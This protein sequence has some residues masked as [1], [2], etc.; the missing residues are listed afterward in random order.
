MLATNSP[1][2]GVYTIENDLS[3]RIAAAST[4]IGAIVG[5]SHRGPVGVP[6]LVVDQAD[7]RAQFGLKDA[8]LSYMHYCAE[9]FLEEASRMYVVRVALEAKH[10]GIF[11]EKDN[12][13][14]PRALAAGFED[15]AEVTFAA[16]DVLFFY[17]ANPGEWNNKLR[18]TIYPKVSDPDGQ[19]FILQIFEGDS[20]IPVEQFECTTHDNVDGSGTQTF[21]EDVINENSKVVRV[22]L[23]K[24]HPEFAQ[25][26]KPNLMNA[27]CQGPLV[28]GDN[29]VDV[30]M[31]NNESL[32]AL[33]DAWDL[34]EDWE[35]IDVN[36]LINA[37]YTHVAFQ[38]KMDEI[39]RIRQDCIAV[40]DVPKNDQEASEAVA[41][42]RNNFL[43]STSSS[44]L[45]SPNLL[46]RDE[47][48]GRDVWVPPSGHIAAVYARTD[49]DAATWFAPAGLIRGQ[50]K[51]VKALAEDY[52]LGHRD[53]LVENQINSIRNMSGNG[54]VVWGAD[55]AYST[56]S[57]LTDVGVRRMLA[58]L[59]ASVRLNNLS[60]VFEPNDDFLRSQQ[61]QAGEALL[62]P[63]KRGRGLYW[64]EV[65]C[66]K[67]NNTDNLIGNGDLIVDYYLDP[68]RFVKRI[69]LNAIIPRTG[70]IQFAE[71]LI[72]STN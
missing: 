4:S 39:A 65:I 41:W 69:H 14:V 56:P 59:H 61:R 25:N 23:N 24:A 47:I 21:I 16:N 70:G 38:H 68:T 43:L 58:F 10:G 32:S 37:G 9:A 35:L 11:F 53:I 22:V 28:G 12:F 34:F 31:S 72:D 33:I 7:F 19:L 71:S 40:L 18:I 66:D 48:N 55:T 44:A 36:I 63:I 1:S 26:P 67:R 15:L 13:S 3:Q 62:E 8:R 17:G 2:A 57:A 5:A 27:I 42:R 30:Q 60:P 45:Y 51:G 54:I 50:L 6:T 46:I 64:Y 49:T 20:S 29:G 52:K